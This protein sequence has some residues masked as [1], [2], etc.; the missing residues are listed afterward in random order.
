MIVGVHPMTNF[1]AKVNRAG[2]EGVRI[3][4]PWPRKRQLLQ[5]EIAV[6]FDLGL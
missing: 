5:E 3:R 4:Q 2:Q 6:T 1:A